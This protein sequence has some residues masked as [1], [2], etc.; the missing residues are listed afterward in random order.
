MLSFT[1]QVHCLRPCVSVISGC[2]ATW[3]YHADHCNSVSAGRRLTIHSFPHGQWCQPPSS[4]VLTFLPTPLP[5]LGLCGV[6]QGSTADNHRV[7][8][9]CAVLIL[10]SHR[11]AHDA[12]HVAAA[13]AAMWRHTPCVVTLGHHPDEKCLSHIHRDE[14]VITCNFFLI[15]CMSVSVCAIVS[16]VP[17]GAS[18]GRV[19]PGADIAGDWELPQWVRAEPCL[20]ARAVSTPNRW[21]CL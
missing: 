14:F 2:S 16:A 18:R 5:P 4:A 15:M 17:A 11:D 21:R 6:A 9:V 8:G 20:P 13:A 12:S 1:A 10:G 19:I 3:S 7:G